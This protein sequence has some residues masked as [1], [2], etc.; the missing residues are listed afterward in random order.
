VPERD[1]VAGL[2]WLLR[3]NPTLL[4]AA[5]DD[6]SGVDINRRARAGTHMCLHCGGRAWTA[7]VADTKIGARWLDLCPACARWFRAGNDALAMENEINGG[8]WNG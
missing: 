4:P 6:Y 2:Q 7:Y 8:A 1:G 3:E 5:P